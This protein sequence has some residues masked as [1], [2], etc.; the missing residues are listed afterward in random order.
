MHPETGLSYVSDHSCIV[1]DAKSLLEAAA[2][3]SSASIRSQPSASTRLA[4]A[5]LQSDI[6]A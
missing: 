6:T 3:N 1:I 5:Q 2:D 4:R